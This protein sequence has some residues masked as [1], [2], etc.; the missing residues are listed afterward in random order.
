MSSPQHFPPLILRPRSPPKIPF[1]RRVGLV[2]R[3]EKRQHTGATENLSNK[4]GAFD[5]KSED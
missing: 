3:L 5:L 2:W 1:A 4:N